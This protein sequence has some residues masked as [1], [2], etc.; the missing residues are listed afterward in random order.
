MDG[1]RGQTRVAASSPQTTSA[2][3]RER[4]RND[5]HRSALSAGTPLANATLAEISQRVTV[6]TYD[7]AALTPAVVHVSVGGFHRAHQAAYF[8]DLAQRRVSRAWGVVGVGLRSRAVGDAL[9]PQDCLYTLVERGAG[10]DRAR[11]IGA[12]GRYLFA[13]ERPRAVLAALTDP[14]TRVV[15]LTVTAGAYHVDSATGAF[16]D[17]ASEIVADAADPSRPR[18]A[19]GYLV[20]ALDRR[21]AAGLPG[22]TV[23]SCDNVTGNGA[24]ARTAVLALA[25]M[26][27]ERLAEW[28]ARNVTFPSSMVDRITPRTTDAD[29]ELV[30]RRFGVADRWPV[31]TEPYSQWVIED[32]FANGRPPL[33]EVGVHFAADV[34]PYSLMKTRLLNASH[35]A[36]GLLGYLAG[37]RRTDVAMRD[38]LFRDYVTALMED[39]V[40]PLLPPVPGIDLG[41]YQRTLIE[42]LGNPKLGDRLA[43]LCRAGSAKIA[44]H[45][46]PSIREARAL[47]RPHDLLTLAVAGWCRY[48]RGVDERGAEIA[49]D[50]AVGGRLQPLAGNGCDGVRPLLADRAVFGDLGHDEGFVRSVQ[51]SLD[52]IERRGVRGAMAAAL[53]PSDAVAA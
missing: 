48:L 28:I 2:V 4:T 51:R 26:R 44:S 3:P 27:D 18:S 33:D 23:L 11:V 39:E 53:A 10:P 30:L 14:R 25:R 24:I 37:E 17:G 12:I 45:V 47:G 8:D 32:E 29:R 52:D 38:P 36:L 1:W 34:R 35:C 7:R 20:E 40:G 21:R 9:T 5:S 42:R 22:F 19:L 6:P 15:T 50:D 49:I 43:R 16:D 41:D 13:P 46:L 31:I